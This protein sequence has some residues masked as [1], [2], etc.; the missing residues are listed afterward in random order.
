MLFG[1][2]LGGQFL[3]ALWRNTTGESEG[4]PWWAYVI[5]VVGVAWLLLAPRRRG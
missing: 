3:G 2:T 1:L 5:V 4:G